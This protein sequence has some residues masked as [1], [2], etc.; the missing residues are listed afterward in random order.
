MCPNQGLVKMWVTPSEK[1]E[2]LRWKEDKRREEED[3]RMQTAI[4][5]ALSESLGG[6]QPQAR[7]PQTSR[8]QVQESRAE[9]ERI[10]LIQR[11]N[12]LRRRRLEEEEYELDRRRRERESAARKETK[13]QAGRNLDKGKEKSTPRREER[14]T[15]SK[16]RGPK[17]VLS[18]VGDDDSFDRD[19]L[20]VEAYDEDLDDEVLTDEVIEKGVEQVKKAF[21]AK[22]SKTG[23][24]KRTTDAVNLVVKLVKTP[25]RRM[26]VIRRIAEEFEL[27][28]S[29]DD[30]LI[31]AVTKELNK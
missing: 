12:D 10:A 9:E 31:L 17:R 8:Y 30:E 11:E 27:E 4:Q 19:I 7:A 2:F 6:L 16:A 20:N 22:K 3:R 29:N 25:E 28:K 26:K 21:D 1:E 14:S 23:P 18:L 13:R 15:P 5:R 24:Y